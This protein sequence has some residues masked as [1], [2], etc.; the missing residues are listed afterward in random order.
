MFRFDCYSFDI[1][2]RPEDEEGL[3]RAVG[4]INELV[5]L[6]MK[7]NNIPSDRIIIGGISQGS[8]VSIL[9]ALTST[10]P[11][12]G[13]FILSG[14]IPLRK[15]AKE[16]GPFLCYF[17]NYQRPSADSLTDRPVAAYILGPW[18]T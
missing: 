10:R 14:Y 11:F 3:Y 9:T 5:S 16:A 12:A 17:N 1:P 18:H 2:N 13:V 8:A 6:E 7:N 4:H 15:K